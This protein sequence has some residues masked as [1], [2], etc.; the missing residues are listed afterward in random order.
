M[1]M[2]VATVG[3]R[4]TGFCSACK[5]QTSGKM[6]SGA[7]DRSIEGK[8]ICVSGS[9]GVGDC[10]HSCKAIGQSQVLFIDSL[11][12][13]RAGDPVIGEIVGKIIEGSDFVSC[14]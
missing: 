11:P 1:P 3:C 10:G 8:N 14:D 7:A 13:A 12:V 9:E 2:P 5:S 4:F 6:I